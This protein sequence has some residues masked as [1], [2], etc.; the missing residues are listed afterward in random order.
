MR[1][2]ETNPSS[3][4]SKLPPTSDKLLFG[5]IYRN[6]PQKGGKHS[7]KEPKSLPKRKKQVG[8]LNN[9][10]QK[11]N[12]CLR[13]FVDIE[14]HRANNNCSLRETSTMDEHKIKKTNAQSMN[15]PDVEKE[16]REAGV[17][18]NTIC[19]GC[20]KT[21]KRLLPHL[22]SKN[23][24]ACKDLYTNEELERP[25]KAKTFYEKHKEKI[26]EKRKAHY[27]QNKL[28][29]I[30]KKKAD[31]SK[32]PK[33]IKK[34]RKAHYDENAAEIK[35]KYI[36]KV[37]EKRKNLS[38]L[39][40]LS[41]FR[42]EIVWG[43]VYPCISCHRTCF[44]NG[45]KLF[46]KAELEKFP[47]LHKVVDG[48]VLLE[49]SIFK[50]KGSFFICH[51]CKL[52]ICRNKMPKISSKN[53]LQIYDRPDFLNLTEVENVLIAPRIN[54]MK[55]IRLPRSRMP[56]IKDKIINVPIPLEKIRQNVD[57]LPR[58]FEEASVI[59]IMIKRKKE[60]VSNVFH[61]YVRPNLI[62]K[63]LS[64]LADK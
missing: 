61:H 31:Y 10:L 55:M 6:I 33:S 56:G 30:E 25:S 17:E 35:E 59:P 52:Y 32:D 36:S 58:T 14:K 44:R 64:Y 54:F 53:A 34:K 42:K 39:D 38:M 12:I 27:N 15:R 20:S 19:R 41:T 21:F 45:V 49:G 47:I 23:G 9:E 2:N 37:K 40:S 62:K 8:D 50:T 7:S 29:I 13:S 24:G 22:H 4:A 60:F 51:N 46:K 18:A 5:I 1:K 26:K 43:A 11:C 48:D 28:K 3:L 63:A 16:T 57:C